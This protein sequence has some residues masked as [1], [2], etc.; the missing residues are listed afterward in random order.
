MVRV[1]GRMPLFVIVALLLVIGTLVALLLRAAVQR[2]QLA[3]INFQLTAEAQSLRD[4]QEGYRLTFARNPCPM[5]LYDS[6]TLQILQVNDAAVETYGYS[7]EE[8]QQMT[9]RDLR[10]PEELAEFDKVIA[11]RRRGLNDAGIWR[12]RCKDGS[13]I[14]A[15]IKAFGFS[16]GGQERELVQARNVTERIRMEE[17][18]RQSQASIQSLLDNA[19][20]GICRTSMEGDCY[21][22][23]NSTMRDILGGYSLEEGLRL[24]LSE[25]VYADTGDR[26]RTAEILR[27]NV[28][29]R[30]YETTLRRRDGSKVPVRI[31]GALVRD[32]QGKEHFEGYVE[33]MTQ[34]S[35]LEQQFR[36]AQKLEAVGRLAGGVAHD[37]NNIL[38]VIKL[39]TEM[40]LAEVTPENPLSKPLLQVSNAADRAAA[41]TRQMLAFGRQQIMQTRIINLNDIVL[42]TSQMLRRII[43][44]DIQLVTRLS[45]SVENSRLDP[46]QVTQV[47]LNL[48]VNARDA[49][50]Q[51]GTLHLETATVDLDDAYAKT[52]PP[53]R[54]G[55][56]VMLAVSDTGSGIDKSI[57]PRIFDP[58]FTT[59]ELGKGTGLGLSIVYGIVKQSGGY[60]WVYTEPAHGTAFKLYFP[61]TTAALESPVPRSE[62]SAGPGGETILLVEDDATIRG[63]IRLCLEQLGYRVMEAENGKAALQICAQHPETIHLVLTDLVMPDMGG[64]DL[65]TRIARLYPDINMLVYVRVHRR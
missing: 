37:F 51:G 50:P 23:L 63:N 64:H 15:D 12:H 46:D 24:K 5:W 17:A 56:Y 16:Q 1:S 57:L 29:I 7:R 48:A 2:R 52:H 55:R 26:G 41:L 30:G 28:T 9:L 4:V 31:S 38:L 44:E 11:H 18:L 40:M 61:A 10:P 59:K 49:M 20:I 54:P 32:A 21:E 19:P 35:T 8:F 43:G 3:Q 58:F 53:V 22:A 33:D 39:S 65:A 60:I 13:F 36:Q 14:F 45:E 34:Q 42:E 47:I 27:R 25:H 6:H 62:T